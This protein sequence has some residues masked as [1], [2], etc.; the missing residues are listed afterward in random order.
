LPRLI[1]SY[2]HTF[3]SLPRYILYLAFILPPSLKSVPALKWQIPIR[4]CGMTPI[5]KL[6][7]STF[8]PN[9]SGS[10][11]KIISKRVTSNT[12]KRE[13]SPCLSPS[14]RN[15]NHISKRALNKLNKLESLHQSVLKTESLIRYK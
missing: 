4:Q 1:F 2:F 8:L 11:L 9:L 12:L 3:L 14:Y 13:I 6:K 10:W 15:S 7:S 5:I